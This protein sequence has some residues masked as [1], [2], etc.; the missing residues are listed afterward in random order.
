MGD[1]KFYEIFYPGGGGGWGI[2]F[3]MEHVIKFM[4]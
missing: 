4:L 2:N 1:I 3:F